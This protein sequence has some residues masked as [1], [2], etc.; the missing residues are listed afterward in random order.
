MFA[1]L[2]PGAIGTRVD[3]LSQGLE[4]A[5]R[6]GFAGYHFGIA[7][8]AQLGVDRVRDL[9]AQTGV[10]LSAFGFPL[11]F[12]GD[13]EDFEDSLDELDGLA[14]VAA[15][16]DV[17]RTATWISPAS[18]E[19]TFEENFELHVRRLRPGAEILAAHG[20][21]LGLEYV[22]PLRSRESR[23]HPFVHTMDQMAE[24]CAAIGPNA[25]FLLDAW[26]WYTAGENSTHLQRL[27]PDQVVDVHVSDAPDKPV[28]AQVDN[29][30]ELPGA[31]G[32]I[33]IVTFLTALKRIGYE[34]PVMVEPFSDAVREMSSDDA[35]AATAASL[36]MVWDQAG[37]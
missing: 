14:A 2:S 7:E 6:H 24:L 20:I 12:R 17:R 33:D 34:G 30:R 35:C 31:T 1:S 13:E 15:A 29:Q 16:L 5:A 3:G 9:C 19:L 28:D 27:D 37:L 21:H 36:R 11:D 10:L 4:L 18:D 26:H 8:V 23:K 22:G 32:V 25:G